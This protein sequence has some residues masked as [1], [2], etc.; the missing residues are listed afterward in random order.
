MVDYLYDG[1]FDGLMTCIY[2]H[3]YNE[4]AAGIFRK[5][6]YQKN[7][8]I[9]SVEVKT[10]EKKAAVVYDAIEKKI[11]PF[12]LRR[13]YKVFMSSCEGK[14]TK[15][16]NY[17]RLGFVKGGYISM[18]HGEPIVY[19]VQKIEKKVGNEIHRMKGLIRFAEVEGGVLYSPI[20]PDHDIVEFLAD[21]FCDRYKN[22]P[23]IIHD[24][25]RNKALVAYQGDWYITAFNKKISLVS[26]NE[27]HYRELWKQYFDTIAIKERINPRCQRN[28]MPARY[29]KNL[30]EF[31]P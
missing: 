27:R 21:H 19:D 24:T 1:T 29:W 2:Y 8:L 20:E 17:V 18:L 4:K 26:E 11:S 23:F 15:I 10:D 7:M 12:D 5:D 3:Y 31:Q 9:A 13:I 16:L 30:T 25:K 22:E 14:E 28:Q 6:R